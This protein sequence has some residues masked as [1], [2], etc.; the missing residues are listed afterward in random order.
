M[1]SANALVL[2]GLP[3]G[4]RHCLHPVIECQVDSTNHPALKDDLKELRPD[5][6]EIGNKS[7]EQIRK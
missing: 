4:I 2:F 7:N 1:T 3:Q 5:L 6:T